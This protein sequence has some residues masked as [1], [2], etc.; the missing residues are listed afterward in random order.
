[1]KGFVIAAVG[2]AALGW[3]A[4]GW[5]QVQEPV[6][7]QEAPQAE[8]PQAEGSQPEPAHK[9]GPTQALPLWELGLGLGGIGFRDYRGSDTTHAYPVPIAYFLYRGRYLQTDRSGLKTKLPIGDR[10]ELNVSLHATTPVRNNATRE[11]MPDLRTTVEIGPALE[12]HV[13]RSASERMSLDVRLPIRA[14]FAVGSPGY[15]GWFSNPNIN[16]DISDAAG[17]H[18]LHLGLLTG[19]LFAASQYDAYY[20]SVAPQYATLDRPTYQA[21]GGYAGSQVLAALSKRYPKF[22]AGAYVRYDSLAGASFEN[23]PL[24][25][26]RSYWSAGIGVA[27]MIRHSARFVDVPESESQ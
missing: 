14:A 8:G 17:V 13:W 21:T 2:L 26:S 10:L 1:M 6:Q 19:P 5:A 20:Y 24:V 3:A 7:G 4:S 15:I 16:L 23:S 27:W 12:V 18:G 11:G 9:A 22:W 25:K